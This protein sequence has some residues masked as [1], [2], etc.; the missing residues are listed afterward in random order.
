ML[1]FYRI[2]I[3]ICM[4]VY[5]FNLS[6]VQGANLELVKIIK[7]HFEG[8]A[9]FYVTLEAKNKST[10]EVKVYQARVVRDIF[11]CSEPTIVELFRLKPSPE[12]KGNY[13]FVYT[14]SDLA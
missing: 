11:D 1:F 9:R 5:V 2:I 3:F 10:G 14:F 12:Q 6:V 7:S 4:Y 13:Y 8:V